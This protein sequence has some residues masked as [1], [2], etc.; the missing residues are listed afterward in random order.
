MPVHHSVSGHP[1]AYTLEL[2]R[3]RG[4]NGESHRARRWWI[5]A[6]TIGLLLFGSLGWHF[7]GTRARPARLSI[8]H[9]VLRIYDAESTLLWQYL[10]PDW[11]EPTHW[12]LEVM[13]PPT[14]L[15]EDI[16]Q[17][18]RVEV[19]F[20]YLPAYESENEGK[21]YCF[22][23]TGTLRWQILY[24]RQLQLNDRIIGQDFV[25]LILRSLEIDR[26]PILLSVS[27]HR[28]WGYSQAA[29]LD[30]EDGSLI[31]EFWHPGILT[32]AVVKDL[33]DDDR[34]ELI[35][36]GLNNPGREPGRPGLMELELPFS[37]IGVRPESQFG[38]FSSGGPKRYLLFPRPDTS[39]L[40][41]TMAL[42]QFFW[43][44]TPDLLQVA[45]RSSKN[46]GNLTYLLDRTLQLKHFLWTPDL[47]YVHD[48]LW[49]EGQLDHPMSGDET[50]CLGDLLLLDYVPDGNSTEF[51]D[52]WRKCEYFVR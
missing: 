17:D 45:V 1:I 36:A 23:D 44:E 21:L 48:R 3:W 2:D 34:P 42:I 40:M 12:G 47:Y 37:R 41:G 7:K 27:G 8:S 5:A 14:S 50:S 9:G 4:Q 20:N 31:E 49:K 22:D 15:I 33:D 13:E 28:R 10:V 16:D 18:G 46:G 25:G 11:E 52:R 26:E 30:P 35:L 19:L 43:F 39:Y 32:H 51:Q 6:V 38:Q 24:G 29:L